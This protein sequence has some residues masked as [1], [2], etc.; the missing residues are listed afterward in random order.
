MAAKGIEGTLYILTHHQQ[1]ESAQHT[2]NITS[3]G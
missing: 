1:W 3:S 2:R